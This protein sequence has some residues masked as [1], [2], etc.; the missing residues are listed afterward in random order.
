MELEFNR[1]RK[2]VEV[3]YLGWKS[4]SHVKF[5]M[6]FDSQV[7][8]WADERMAGHRNLDFREDVRAEI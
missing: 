4:F 6:L 5:E 7:E 1:L 3:G 2:L 8:R